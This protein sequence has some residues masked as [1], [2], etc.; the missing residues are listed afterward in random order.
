MNAMKIIKI[1]VSQ[2]ARDAVKAVAASLDMTE[3][4][5][6]TRFYLWFCEQPEEIRVVGQFEI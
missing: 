3:Q 4:G 1:K 6:A 2:E 5:V